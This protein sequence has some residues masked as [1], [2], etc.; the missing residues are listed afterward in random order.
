MFVSNEDVPNGHA[1]GTRVLLEGIVLKEDIVPSTLLIDGLK[2]PTVEASS[3]D[4]L[5][6]SLVDKKEKIFY[7][8]PKTFNCSVRAPVPKDIGGYTEASVNLN[9]SLFQFPV[10]VNNATTGHKLQGQTKK[11][12]IISVWSKK[13]N[14]NYVALSRVQT[15]KGLYLVT[16]LPP[17]TDFSMS[18]DLRQMLQA[19]E[20][21]S[22]EYVEWNLNEERTILKRKRRD[23]DNL[24]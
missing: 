17:T 16:P 22:P 6:C 2:C 13:K 8:R 19:L 9:V 10:L 3:I 21:K 1:N 24:D 4:H 12:L 5:V 23:S 18:N 7:I 11:N 20:D 15:R 14:W